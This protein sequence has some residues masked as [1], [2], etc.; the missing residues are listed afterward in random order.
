MRI[1]RFKRGD[2]IVPLVAVKISS[3]HCD[4][5]LP[6]NCTVAMKDGIR[7]LV[8]R[9]ELDKMPETTQN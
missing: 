3:P 7:Y 5:E 9:V 4:L 6:D 2:V 1:E 8:P